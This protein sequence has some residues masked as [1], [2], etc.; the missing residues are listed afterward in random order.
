ML[1][2]IIK[3]SIIQQK[4]YNKHP[5]NPVKR[6]TALTSIRE[7]KGYKDATSPVQHSRKENNKKADLGPGYDINIS[8]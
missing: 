5:Q 8:L 1:C 4:K 6:V 3:V 7:K 2:C